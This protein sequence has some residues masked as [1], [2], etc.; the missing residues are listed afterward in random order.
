LLFLFLF[1]N[2]FFIDFSGVGNY[3]CAC[4]SYYNGTYCQNNYGSCDPN[5]CKNGATCHVGNNSKQQDIYHFY[6]ILFYF[7]L[8]NSFIYSIFFF[9]L[10]RA[11]VLLGIMGPRAMNG[12]IIALQ[13]HVSMA[14][15]LTGQQATLAIAIRGIME[16]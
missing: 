3:G 5:P 4:P 8:F 11:Y 2:L 9:K 14:R 13:I 6:F 16:P 1:F 10:T 12:P 15:V 7:S